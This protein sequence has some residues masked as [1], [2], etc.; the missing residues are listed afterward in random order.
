[1]S[2]LEANMDKIDKEQLLREIRE[3]GVE[4]S[5]INDL[6]YINK[7]HKDLIPILLRH[8]NEITDESDKQYIVRCLGVKGFTEVTKPMID[9]FYKSHNISYKWAIGNTLYITFDKKSLPE[10]L[11]IV[12]NKNHGI[13]RQMIVYGLGRFK[14][15]Q[16][17]SVLVN[18]LQ[19]QDVVGHAIHALSQLGDPSVLK[20]I[21]PFTN[22]KI[23][24]IRNE[25]KKAIKKLSKT[26]RNLESPRF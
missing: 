4:I 20:D 26:K 23:T 7:K 8:L 17:K 1:V 18:L 24:W 22:Y 19:D 2:N 25:A 16:V 10:L 5:N 21:E 6:I 12:L 3:K 14:N 13:S 11:N 15:E 9:E